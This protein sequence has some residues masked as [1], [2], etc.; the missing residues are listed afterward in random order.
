M[1]SVQGIGFGVE[2]LDLR[3]EEGLE[4]VGSG[5]PSPSHVPNTDEP[6]ANGPE[7]QA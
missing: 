7:F 5:S 6:L 3:F 2:G 4:I 1:F